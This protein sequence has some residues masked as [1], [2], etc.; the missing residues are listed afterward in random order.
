MVA[1]NRRVAVSG[2]SL[3]LLLCPVA[4]AAAAAPAPAADAPAAATAPD[5]VPLPD[6]GAPT[7]ATPFLDAMAPLPGDAV[8]W[9]TIESTAAPDDAVP[10]VEV[11]VRYTVTVTGLAELGQM[12]RFNETSQLHKSR[13]EPANIAQIRRRTAADI[14]LIEQLLRAQGY[15]GSTVTSRIVPPTRTGGAIGVEITVTPGPLYKFTRI[16]I[17]A[18]T[19]DAV[20]VA[21]KA[22]GLTP[23]TVAAAAPFEAAQAA[24]RG[25]LAAVGHPF[26]EIGDPDIVIDH[27]E[28]AALLTQKIDPGPL[29]RFGS[30]R[31]EGAAQITTR[32]MQR[33]VRFKPG[34]VYNAA[35]IEDLRRA[36]IATSLFGSV[37]IKPVNA[38][39]NPDGSVIVD[40]VVT[41]ET[42]PLRSV[43]ASAGYSTGEGWRVAGS[44]QHRNLLPPQG[45]V[46][47]NALVAQ[48]ELGLGGELRR[49]N[50]LKR[51]RT[52]VLSALLST[53]NQDAYDAT[54]L[55]VGGLVELETNIIWQKKWYYSVG[56]EFAASNEADLS[57]S[58]GPDTPRTLYYILSAPL[59]LSYD[60]SNDL[61]NPERGFRLN[62]R[63]SP[64]LSFESG[65]FGYV[66]AQ[67]EGSYYQPL[68][69][70]FTLA[71]RL[72]FGSIIGASRGNVAP[73]RRFY[74]GGGGSV[75]GY[76]Y[77]QVGPK[78]AE[79]VPTG[80]NSLTEASIEARVRF[81]DWGVVPFI[82]A[83]QVYTGTL[84]NFSGMS[85]GAGVGVRYFTSFGPIRVDVA[86]PLNPGPNDPKIAFYVSIGQAF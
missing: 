48:R 63:A 52:L 85:F 19:A 3:A 22:L 81:G 54:T 11:D 74:A 38:G 8:A 62:L 42:A 7:S 83:G 58:T 46:T 71:G 25:H 13:N 76:D 69:S 75:R 27:A 31:S 80:G 70:N 47:V 53:Q 43:S 5:P 77:Q 35:D 49:R 68:G 79:G 37:V 32:H 10:A 23:G 55:A 72:H 73:T 50:W 28:T 17:I 59:S 40:L 36:L 26:P 86:T 61:L 21:S 34:D 44:W 15:F 1:M 57:A 56:V 4:A 2:A 51:D 12:P 30:V 20:L 24:L 66:R 6:D 41:G 9:P 29:G 39:T 78:D 16:D 45:A 14:A 33:L 84:P 67:I 82:D 18:P 60:G 65:T 64:Q